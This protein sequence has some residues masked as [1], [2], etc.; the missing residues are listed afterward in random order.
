[1]IQ[2]SIRSHAQ[3][4]SQSSSYSAAVAA[5]LA[6]QA[7]SDL[8]QAAA[9]GYRNP[10]QYRYEPALAPL[11]GCDDFRLLLLDLGFPADP[12]AR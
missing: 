9:L 12:F 8:R 3:S 6:D 10:A 1:M 4:F 2:I 11:R 7:M 5:E